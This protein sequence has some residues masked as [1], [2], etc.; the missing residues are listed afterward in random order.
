[1]ANAAG[2]GQRDVIMVAMPL[3]GTFGLSSFLAAVA[4]GARVVVTD[5]D[6][7]RTATLIEQ[8]R[9]TCVN[10][11][12]DMFHRLIEHGADLSSIRLGGYARFNSSLEGVV[13]RAAEAGA[14]LVGL[15]GMSEV[16]A[17][18]AMRSPDGDER[19][20]ERAGGRLSSPRA[21]YRVVDGELQLRGPSLFAGYL[22]EGGAGV[23]VELT[24]R[25]LDDGWFCTGDLASPD[26][27]R[28]FEYVTRMGDVLRLGGFLVSPAEIEGV[29]TEVDGVIA[30]QVVAIERPQG[31]RPVAFVV[32]GEGVTVDEQIAI[33]A[34]RERLAIYKV[35][36][37]VFTVEAFPTTP[38]AN[39]TKIQKSKLRELALAALD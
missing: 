34:C 10:G 17:L 32:A 29:L 30:A 4:G 6:T 38:S 33:A 3:C 18:F 36:I 14:R 11:S 13:G 21:E 27:A 16:Q 35:P 25:H 1:M 28:T 12:D 7:A 9:V 31:A 8:E 24:R 5:Y 23:D 20:R 39:G 37:R 19:E 2:Y 22:T 26:D 15:Y